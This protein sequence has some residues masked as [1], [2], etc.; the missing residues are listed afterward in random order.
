[1]Q[2]LITG[3]DGSDEK[4]LE[5]RMAV[6]EEHLA[7]VK[8]MADEKKHLYGA[9]LLDENEKM[10]GSFLVVDFPSREELDA[11]LKIEPYVVGNVWQKIEV[12]PCKVAPTFME[13]YK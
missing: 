5:R 7:L 4:A 6:R 8:N 1:M 11:Y 2:F 12:T 10:I 3:Y 9:A 13:L